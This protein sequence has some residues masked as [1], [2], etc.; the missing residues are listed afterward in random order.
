MNKIKNIATCLLFVFFIISCSNSADK[1]KIA[2]YE[3]LIDELQKELK[4]AQNSSETQNT[5]T[6]NQ[7]SYSDNNSYSETSNSTPA[8]SDFASQESTN[9]NNTIVGV[10]EFTDKL[11][12][13]WVMEI[14]SDETAVIYRKGDNGA[15]AYGS[16]FKYSNMKNAQVS[17]SDKGPIVGFP[18]GEVTLFKPYFN[19]EWIYSRVSAADAKNPELRLA[20]K[21]IK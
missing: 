17:F 5:S 16:W 14:N 12:H 1:A 15:K 20:L 4:S 10:Y 7:D 13:T 9:P 2:Y 21:K 6:I 8:K 19:D 3:E 18:S 11:D